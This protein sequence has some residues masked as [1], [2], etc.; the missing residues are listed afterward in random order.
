MRKRRSIVIVL[1]CLLLLGFVREV[2]AA[3]PTP[4]QAVTSSSSP[5][6]EIGTE[7]VRTMTVEYTLPYPGILPTHPLFVLK[8]AR[9]WIFE[10]LITD[11][12]RKT[13]FYIL[14]SDKRIAMAITFMQN[15]QPEE[16][17]SAV[18]DAKDFM[19]KAADQAMI[20]K[21]QGQ[22]IPGH[23][24]DRFER[25]IAKHIEVVSAFS[26]QVEPTAGATFRE[27]LAAYQSLQSDIEAY[28]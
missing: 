1:A 2:R 21:D 25:A 16:A 28:K 24:T 15:V 27:S 5:A 26:S 7:T 11:P 23:I 14:Q 8:M 19:K 10:Q 22:E 9:D 3:T 6:A 13:E 4:T 18:V 20:I 12:L 17:G